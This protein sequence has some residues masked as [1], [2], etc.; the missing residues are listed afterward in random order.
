VFGGLAPLAGA[1]DAE[2]KEGSD[3][4]SDS[5][6]C[7]IVSPYPDAAAG[8]SP[9]F[10]SPRAAAMYR[11]HVNLGGDAAE[12][13]DSP[14]DGKEGF[15]ADCPSDSD[16]CET[17][18]P[19]IGQMKVAC[20]NVSGRT[21]T[22][23]ADGLA[24]Y[25]SFSGNYKLSGLPEF[26]KPEE[27]A[28]GSLQLSE[29][30]VQSFH[31][32]A[33]KMADQTVNHRMMQSSHQVVRYIMFDSHQVNYNNTAAAAAPPPALPATMRTESK[34][35]RRAQLQ[36]ELK[37]IQASIKKIEEEIVRMK[38]VYQDTFAKNLFES[39]RAPQASGSPPPVD[40]SEEDENNN[41]DAWVDPLAL[42]K[43]LY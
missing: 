21:A 14:E 24:F 43:N 5:E 9:F 26:L 39:L 32:K 35:S 38:Q 37:R 11:T 41:A 33:E 7:D 3:C 12:E 10:S 29:K 40:R 28:P 23:P 20:S 18:S 22:L 1:G 30:Q 16:S 17:I 13:T 27:A 2:A 8:G 42:E 36:E 6:S 15:E 4:S 34:Q 31:A 25:N 19:D